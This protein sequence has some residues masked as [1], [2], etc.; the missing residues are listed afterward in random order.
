VD[1]NDVAGRTMT[2]LKS[3]YDRSPVP[4]Y[5]Q[6]A[7][8]LRSRIHNG[9][10]QAGQ[11]IST[12]DVLER[13]FE[14]AR[15]TVRQAVELLQGEGL[16]RSEQ[17]RG[18]FVAETLP[19]QRWLRLETSWDALVDS[20]RENE[21]RP[22]AVERP[23]PQ[24]TLGEGDGA[25]APRYVFLRSVQSKGGTPYSVVSVHLAREIY[26]RDPKGFRSRTALPVLASLYRANIERAHQSLVIGAA[27]LT[28]AHLLQVP[29]GTP[30]AESRCVVVDRKGVA[31]Y[32]A[33]IVYRNDVVKL[34]IQL[35]DDSKPTKAKN[36]PSPR[37]PR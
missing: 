33:E 17:G 21:I 31:I 35:L 36:T 14:V 10:W 11:K 18:T 5:I 22:I 4:L 29:L 28:T 12:L 16:L 13:E 26:E 23:P 34:H 9:Q 7:Q 8:A 24:P 30:T 25:P 2:S 6:V 19:D 27:D 20:I 32:V 37:K 15:I 1:D 3:V